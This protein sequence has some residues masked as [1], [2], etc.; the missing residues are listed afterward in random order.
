LGAG[1]FILYKNDKVAC[2]TTLPV[3]FRSAKV[4]S[5]Y[6][7][8]PERACTGFLARAAISGFDDRQELA[9]S[10][11]SKRLGPTVNH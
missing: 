11:L 5:L 4:D 9:T 8:R 2:I 3:R 1:G 6:G 7:L 10:F